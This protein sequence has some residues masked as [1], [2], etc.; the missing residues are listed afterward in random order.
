MVWPPLQPVHLPAA[1]QAPLR[2]QR[3]VPAAH[4]ALRE[5][6]VEPG[7]RR[8]RSRARQAFLQARALQAAERLVE[9]DFELDAFQVPLRLL[10]APGEPQ[11]QVAGR[12]E[13][14]GERQVDE[15]AEGVAKPS[16]RKL[17]PE[18][19]RNERLMLCFVKT[20]EHKYL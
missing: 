2:D 4:R 16:P 9:R 17:S 8:A 6:E 1:R 19:Q 15:R 18:A 12:G 5:V 10:I 20:V 14:L 11:E 7:R 13:A 3:P